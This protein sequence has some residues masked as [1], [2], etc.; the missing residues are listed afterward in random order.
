[1]KQICRPCGHFYA[2][3]DHHFKVQITAKHFHRSLY[4]SFVGVY[5][6]DHH[7]DA[8]PCL[9]DVLPPL[10]LTR[11]PL[12]AMLHLFMAVQCCYLWL[13]TQYLSS[14][15]VLVRSCSLSVFLFELRA[16]VMRFSPHLLVPAAVLCSYTSSV[17]RRPVSEQFST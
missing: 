1:M 4:P 9:E 10:A 8:Q 13:F 2:I 7:V 15:A 12:F 3:S 17:S 11:A 5:P 6:T 16:V 14:A